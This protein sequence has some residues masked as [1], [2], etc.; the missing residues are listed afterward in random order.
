MK[1]RIAGPG[2]VRSLRE[3]LFLA[4]RWRP[5]DEDADTEEVLADDRILRYVDGWGR[6]GDLGMI[7]ERDGLTIGAA[8]LRLF[9]RE[10]PG[11]AFVDERTPEL[12]VAVTPAERRRGVG[13]ALLRAVTRAAALAGHEAVSLSVE[14]DN[15][16]LR[17]Y[18]SLGFRR[19]EERDGAWTV[20]LDLE[21]IEPSEIVRRGY[22]EAGASYLA[23][24][25]RLE[26]AA[27]LAR[28][29]ELLPPPAT[30]LDIGCGSGIP[31]D[32]YLADQGYNVIGLDISPRQ[33]ELA[34]TRVPRA[35]FEV[36]DML[37]LEPGQFDVDAVVSF[38]AI[39]HTPRRR[40]GDL[41]RRLASFLGPDGVLL[42]T[43]GCDE[44]EGLESEFHGVEMYWSHYGSSRN[45]ELVEEA[46]F[47]VLSDEIQH[48]GSERHQVIL[49][50]R[51]RA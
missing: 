7:A 28:F 10:R 4:A 27:H 14:D 17:L 16:A 30:V 29:R 49:A 5:G 22:D 24:R 20:R 51:S 8:W 11:F 19:V 47:S 48:T 40:H 13:T 21:R 33:I 18:E 2:D 38:Y 43:M 50:R 37:N 32:R 9:T 3:M 12:T 26:N 6:P 25:D 31:I 45:R 15:P 39:F 35:R 36:L 42:I 34:R 46:G 44:H 41:L 23:T 1:I